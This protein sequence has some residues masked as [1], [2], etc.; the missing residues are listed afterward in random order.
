M[1]VSKFDNLSQAETNQFS[2]IEN[3]WA[4]DFINSAALKG[5][6]SGYPD[7][8]FHPDEYIT[9]AEAMTLINSVLNRKVSKE[10]LLENAKYWSDN[11]KDAWYY[12]A[13][14]EATNSHDYT[15]ETADGVE[16][17][18]AITANKTWD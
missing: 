6:I 2:D 1:I 4:K 7:G 10:G 15:R 5:W 16:T 8:T 13:V 18:T 9:R 17:W 3:H 14:M 12:E 11:S